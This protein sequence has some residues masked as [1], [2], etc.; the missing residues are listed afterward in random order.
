MGVTGLLILLQMLLIDVRLVTSLPFC[1]KSVLDH[2]IKSITEQQKAMNA[3]CLFSENITLPQPSLN[4]E[5]TRLQ[6]SQQEAEIHR[7]FQLFLDSVPKVTTFVSRCKLEVSLQRFSSNIRTMTNI[8]KRVTQKTET[9]N[10]EY[11]ERTLSIST[12]Q[13]FYTVYKNFL[14]G[15]YKTVIISLCK[16]LQRR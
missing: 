3:P 14:I 13:Q 4:A 15:K 16:D 8:L 10:L 1:D 9:Q 11:E 5:W 6:T 12:L 7:G 2:F